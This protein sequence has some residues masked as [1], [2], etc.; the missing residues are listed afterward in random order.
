MELCCQYVAATYRSTASSAEQLSFC[1]IENLLP[2]DL[3]FRDYYQQI[4]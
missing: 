2:P 4:R 3:M 1:P